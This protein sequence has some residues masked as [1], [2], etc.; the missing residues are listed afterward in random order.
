MN[1]NHGFAKKGSEL[2]VLSS[3]LGL[4][5]VGCGGGG[6]STTSPPASGGAPTSTPVAT[7][8]VPITTT[9]IDFNFLQNVNGAASAVAAT[10]YDTATGSQVNNLSFG[11]T[12]QTAS[13]NLPNA[14]VGGT[15]STGVITGMGFVGWPHN[16]VDSNTPA[17]AMI[18]QAVAGTGTGRFGKST[19]VL[20]T[21][22]ASA[23]TSAA[24]L[25][26]QSF[27]T[28]SEDC[29]TSTTNS[30]VSATFDASGNATFKVNSGTGLTTINLTASQIN[31]ML[32]GTPNTSNGFTTIN[33]YRYVASSG[34]TKYVLV[35]HGGTTA[36]SPTSGYVAVWL[37]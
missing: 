3:L 31:A 30:G 13:Y 20:I 36:T 34:A 9:F 6:G 16:T 5:I 17:I 24:T 26:G 32:T 23:I 28:V 22:A 37:Q 7:S 18:C 12:R 21:N 11:L 15:Y 8:A 1:K 4:L 14:Y 2:L 29:V 35:E 25:A 10:I 33:A 27:T 19:D